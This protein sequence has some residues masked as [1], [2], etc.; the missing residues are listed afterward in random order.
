[1]SDGQRQIETYGSLEGNLPQ[2]K[3][4]GVGEHLLH[5]D[6]FLRRKRTATGKPQHH[7]GK[8]PSAKTR[9]NVKGLAVHRGHSTCFVAIVANIGFQVPSGYNRRRRGLNATYRA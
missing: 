5:G 8:Q 7:A 1:M 9:C 4:H 6:G 3:Q 2:V